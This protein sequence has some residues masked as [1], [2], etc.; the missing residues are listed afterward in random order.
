METY[1]V[2]GREYQVLELVNVKGQLIPLLDIRVMSDE[3]ERELAQK[4]ELRHE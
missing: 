3:R 1:K 4:G 2:A